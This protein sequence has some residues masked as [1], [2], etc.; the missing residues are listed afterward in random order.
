MPKFMASKFE[1]II[2]GGNT[3]EFHN[4]SNIICNQQLIVIFFILCFRSYVKK[5]KRL[6]ENFFQSFALKN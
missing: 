5:G 1:G 3:R 2:A 4:I 6:K